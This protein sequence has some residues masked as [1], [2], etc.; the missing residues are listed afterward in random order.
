MEET[1]HITG[2]ATPAVGT[3]PVQLGYR[4]RRT[5]ASPAAVLGRGL[6]AVRSRLRIAAFGVTGF[7]G[8]MFGGLLG[9]GGGSA[10]AP[11]L[12]LGTTLRP[13][14]V[15]GTTLASVLVIS[16]V[17]SGTYAS[18]GHLNLGLAM[19][20]AL[21]SVAG[22]VLGAQTS[23]R[24]SMGL[25]VGIFV[26]ILPYF[27]VKEFWPSLA[28]PVIATHVISLVLL[29]LA[30]GFL[31]GLLGISGASLVV[32]SLVGFFLIDHHAAQGIA[33]SV[34]VADSAAGALTHARNGNI[35][36]RILLYM[37]PPALVAAVAGALLSDSLSHTA[38]RYLFGA[39]ILTVW[40]MML[41]RLVQDMA[42][43]RAT[44]SRRS[45]VDVD[46]STADRLTAVN[47]ARRPARV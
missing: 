8:G 7:V 33:M 21:G 28:A 27:A 16:T 22:S 13:A 35:N 41:I 6:S 36:Y 4:G 37:A 17:G 47:D 2:S 38:L 32:P 31:S 11:L 18:L 43:R 5:A 1:R 23:R 9:I 39:F 10:I 34:A 45:P 24:L 14:Q 42:R 20:I 44:A 3:A 19:P 29:G 40:A 46:G 25:M 30:T 15:S 12:L 26:A